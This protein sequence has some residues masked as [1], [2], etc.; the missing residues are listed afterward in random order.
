MKASEHKQEQPA[1]DATGRWR[2]KVTELALKRGW[3]AEALWRR[4]DEFS[5]V[6]EMHQPVS[7]PISEHVGWRLLC[8]FYDT[9]GALP[10]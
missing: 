5:C 8:H 3:S 10:E 7:R 4:F 9:Q 2:R 6:V 1:R